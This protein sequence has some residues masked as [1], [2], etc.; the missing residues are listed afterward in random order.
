MVILISFP[1]ELIYTTCCQSDGSLHLVAIKYFD[2]TEY[3]RLNMKTADR[4]KSSILEPSSMNFSESDLD[5][6]EEMM[7]VEEFILSDSNFISSDLFVSEYELD[8]RASNRHSKAITKISSR[9]R[10]ED[11]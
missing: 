9:F 2:Q 3:F 8:K 11:K 1:Q 6:N 5:Q 7:N 4:N 10:T